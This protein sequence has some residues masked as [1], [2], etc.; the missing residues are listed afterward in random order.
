MEIKQYRCSHQAAG[1]RAVG[2]LCSPSAGCS[3]KDEEVI[4]QHEVNAGNDEK[5]RYILFFEEKSLE[6]I[7]LN[8]GY[9]LK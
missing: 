8:D 1:L 9:V 6:N 5:E 2:V 3:C 4:K 7:C